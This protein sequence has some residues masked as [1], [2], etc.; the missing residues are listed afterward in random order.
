LIIDKRS[1]KLLA[2]TA[3]T[4]TIEGLRKLEQNKHMISATEYNETKKEI[5]SEIKNKIKCMFMNICN[6]NNLQ[7]NSIQF[8]YLFF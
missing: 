8:I 6:N 5:I 7:F 2:F 3:T 4:T 1:T